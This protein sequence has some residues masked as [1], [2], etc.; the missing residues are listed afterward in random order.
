MKNEILKKSKTEMPKNNNNKKEAKY[1][2]GREYSFQ[3]KENSSQDDNKGSGEENKNRIYNKEDE[4]KIKKRFGYDY[5][6]S[7]YIQGSG[8]Q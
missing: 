8:D 3:N 2:Y 7:G 6:D 5:Y 1:S 4:E